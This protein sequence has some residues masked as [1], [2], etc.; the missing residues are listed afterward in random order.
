MVSLLDLYQLVP[1][2]EDAKIVEIAFDIAPSEDIRHLQPAQSIDMC[3]SIRQYNPSTQTSQAL[4]L[5]SQSP[6]D[7]SPSEI[8]RSVTSTEYRFSVED[9]KALKTVELLQRTIDT[10]NVLLD[11][12][13]HTTISEN[14]SE[15]VHHEVRE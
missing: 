2:P 7:Q 9:E 13:T 10:F 11:R 14:A 4:V 5:P 15:E 6:S 3:S 12:L 8:D 1:N